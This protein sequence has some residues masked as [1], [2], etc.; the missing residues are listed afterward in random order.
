MKQKIVHIVPVESGAPNGIPAVEEQVQIR[1]A[2][3]EEDLTAAYSLV[4]DKYVIR[5]FQAEDPKGIRFTP[6]FALPSSHTFIA[7]I[8]TEV[9]GTLTMVIDGALGLPMEKEYPD[10]IKAL[11]DSGRRMA[12]LSCLVTRR[13]KDL[14]ALLRLFH[15][16]YAYA[17]YQQGVTDFCI[18]VTTEHQ[19]FYN[20]AL[21]FEQV[22]AA[23]PYASCN[24]V[25]AVAM[26]LHLPSAKQSYYNAYNIRRM[27]GR[28]F[29][30]KKD[31]E[32]LGRQLV[33]PSKD[34]LYTRLAFA[35]TYLDWSSL[36]TATTQK[37]E[38]AYAESLRFEAE[39][40]ENRML[41]SA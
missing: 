11:R 7:T 25:S 14:P 9:I 18:A 36:Y 24:S 12:E 21:L 37:I 8:G 6:H 2:H 4:Y 15:A 38:N 33:L 17:L 19:R 30:G 41:Q 22:G 32:Q 27:L 34:T 20:N 35:R 28:F 39:H 26:S 40:Q 16:A 23:K 1:L 5:G 29:L 3:T 31:V 13:S 10:E